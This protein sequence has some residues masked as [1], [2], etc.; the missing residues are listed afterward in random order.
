MHAT[1]SNPVIAVAA[2]S[3]RALRQTAHALIRPGPIMPAMTSAM[4][5]QA[6]PIN[7]LRLETGDQPRAG[8]PPSPM[9]S[10]Q[11]PSNPS[12][13]LSPTHSARPPIEREP[14][15]DRPLP[16]IPRI[17]STSAPPPASARNASNNCAATGSIVSTA[18]TFVPPSSARSGDLRGLPEVCFWYW[19]HG[20]YQLNSRPSWR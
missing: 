17:R 20:P 12:K 16:T 14:P 5:R 3:P 19:I 11:I 18:N 9:P 10:H 6:T 8:A 13:K 7:A 2:A 1:N 15:A 4:N